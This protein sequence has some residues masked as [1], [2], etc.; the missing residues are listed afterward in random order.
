[1]L[2]LHQPAHC[3]RSRILTLHSQLNSMYFATFSHLCLLIIFFLLP[4]SLIIGIFNAR[5][6]LYSVTS[7]CL[8]YCSLTIS[9]CTEVALWCYHLTGVLLKAAR[10]MPSAHLCFYYCNNNYYYYYYSA[11]AAL[12][13]PM[14]RSALC[15]YKICNVEQSNRKHKL[16]CWGW[17]SKILPGTS[18]N[19]VWLQELLTH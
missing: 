6:S 9:F 13:S 19:N 1:M 2:P 8:P 15:F 18:K 11:A 10:K 16:N 7:C 4:A 12:D 5:G 17:Q 3:N 14:H